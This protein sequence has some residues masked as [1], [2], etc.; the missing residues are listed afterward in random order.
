[1][2]KVIWCAH[3]AWL[4]KNLGDD[5]LLK[6]LIDV[7]KHAK[8]ISSQEI[9]LI[10]SR[11]TFIGGESCSTKAN[12][13]IF[14]SGTQHFY[15]LP[16]LKFLFKDLRHHFF[17]IPRLF[18]L[19]K[20]FLQGLNLRNIVFISSGFGPFKFP[21]LPIKRILIR[22][23]RN[24]QYVSIRDSGYSKKFAKSDR[25]Y[26]DPVLS[27]LNENFQNLIGSQQVNFQKEVL[28]CVRKWTNNAINEFQSRI[29]E[30]LFSNSE[31]GHLKIKFLFTEEI[32]YDFWKDKIQQSEKLLYDHKNEN[33]VIKYIQESDFVI[34]SRWHVGMISSYFK[35][36][37]LFLDI[38]PKLRI[39]GE[40]LGYIFSSK[41]DLDGLI[42]MLSLPNKSKD[43]YEYQNIYNYDELARLLLECSSAHAPVN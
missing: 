9:E 30:H 24:A 29:I 27:Y 37:T 36:G 22:Y 25:V 40:K 28:V 31:T 33:E 4:N 3:G 42:P 39:L 7:V 38:E 16:N 11:P 19:D 35:L 2:S 41:N 6:S 13:H 20:S 34:T 21:F 14:W 32:D 5:L 18:K 10:L 1:M 23:L 12:L 17:E 8:A 15:H 43:L 26:F